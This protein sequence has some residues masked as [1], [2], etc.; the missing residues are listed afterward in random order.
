MRL[1]VDEL[2]LFA[3]REC[4]LLIEAAEGEDAESLLGRPS[5]E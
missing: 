3:P 5:S 4:N 1:S 2:P